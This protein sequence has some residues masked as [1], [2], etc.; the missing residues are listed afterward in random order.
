MVDD[1]R[2]KDGESGLTWE[3]AIVPVELGANQLG[4]SSRAVSST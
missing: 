2:M 1:E 3:F 4:R